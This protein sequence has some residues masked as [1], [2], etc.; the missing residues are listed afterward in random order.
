MSK[1][2]KTPGRPLQPKRS[3]AGR[4]RQALPQARRQ[5]AAD[6]PNPKAPYR[7]AKSREKNFDT[8]PAEPLNWWLPL[9]L[10]GSV[11]ALAMLLVGTRVFSPEQQVTVTGSNVPA[12][13]SPTAASEGELLLEQA[14]LLEATGDLA[15][16]IEIA[17]LIPKDSETHTDARRQINFWQ[18]TIRAQEA[19]LA[20]T[21]AQAAQVRQ[22]QELAQAQARAAEAQRAQQLAQEQARAAEVRRQQE[23]AQAR[24][25]AAEAQRQQEIAST[26]AQTAQARQQQEAARARIQAAEAQA[27]QAR[28]QQ[29]LAE[30]QAEIGRAHV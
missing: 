9:L 16:A 12:P 7:A 22:Q 18:G 11:G 3:A 25:E 19:E 29:E 13:A 27:N 20:T 26:Q 6:V 15:G 4:K 17:S 10:G 23:I 1:D 8:V 14:N 21:K 2:F 30:A 5:R 24:A 28:Q